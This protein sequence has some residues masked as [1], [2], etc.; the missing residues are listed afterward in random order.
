[1][2]YNKCNTSVKTRN[3]YTYRYFDGNLA[4]YNCILCKP[5]TK[6][7]K[8]VTELLP[9]DNENMIMNNKVIGLN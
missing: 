2:P 8:T 4:I 3:F 6:K 9:N 5:K 1:M 7:T